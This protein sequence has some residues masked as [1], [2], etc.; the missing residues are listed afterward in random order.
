MTISIAEAQTKLAQLIAQ[1]EAGEE[2]FIA[3]S[4]DHPAGEIGPPWL[5]PRPLTRHPD[6]NR[7]HRDPRAS[8]ARAPAGLRRNGVPSPIGKSTSIDLR[9]RAHR[10]KYILDTCTYFWLVDEPNQAL[11]RIAGCDGGRR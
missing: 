8:G 9:T 7:F 4:S 6:L 5:R 3:R 11:R 2:V 10:M 1:A